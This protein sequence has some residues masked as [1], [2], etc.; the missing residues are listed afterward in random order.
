MKSVE[1]DTLQ[2]QLYERPGTMK[3]DMSHVHCSKVAIQIKSFMQADT[4]SG[5]VPEHD[6]IMFYLTNHAV[7]EVRSRVALD[8]PLAAYQ[9]I[10]EK[11]HEALAARA[12]RMFYYLV[13]ICTRESRHVYNDDQLFN[14]LS[15][16]NGAGCMDFTKKINGSGSS[17]AASA[18]K[19][20]PPVSAMGK[21]SQHLV[22]IFYKGKFSGGYGGNAWGQVADVL[23]KFVKGEY[24]A[25]MMMDT[26]F[27]LCHNNGPIFNKGMLFGG[28]DSSE[29]VKIL[30][31]QRAG[32]IPQMVDNQESSK[33]TVEHKEICANFKGI[34]GK[35]F[36][37]YVDW[38]AVEGLGSV[39]NYPSQKQKQANQHGVPEGADS[40]AY[41]GKDGKPKHQ[42]NIPKVESFDPKTQFM[43]MPGLSVK[44]KV[45]N[46]LGV[47]V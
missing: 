24:S 12:V 1:K 32:M 37:G 25:E 9:P 31:V 36:G 27:T 43:I 18:F 38:Y 39:K 21:Y 19:T 29:I 30:D 7:A 23:N 5:R 3:R 2:F 10:L 35:T 44:K 46:E 28:Y 26:A 17:G 33:I 20:S 11:Y 6:A 14:Y 22:D 45:R 13:L 47:Y 8:E 42:L 40:V 16:K 4:D 34:L 15:K 41:K